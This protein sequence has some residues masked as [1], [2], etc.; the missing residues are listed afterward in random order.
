MTTRVRV[1]VRVT[2]IVQGVGFR[3][4]VH[5]LAGTLGL[6]GQVGNDSSGVLLEAEGDQASVRTFLIEL[7]E[8]PPALAVVE[9]VET[10][11]IPLTGMRM[12][13]PERVMIISSSPSTTSLTATT[14]PFRSFALIVMIPLPARWETRYSE[15]S[16]RLP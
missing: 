9:R 2:G 16:L 8:H 10:T 5:G 7:V 14:L 4:F 13:W 3:P 6:S 12:S 15:I 1:R 11:E